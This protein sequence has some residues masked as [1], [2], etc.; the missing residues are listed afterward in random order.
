MRY[1]CPTVGGGLHG[2]AQRERFDRGVCVL[3]CVLHLAFAARR[4]RS[5]P[6][7]A[8]RGSGSPDRDRARHRAPMSL[9]RCSPWLARCARSRSGLIRFTASLGGARAASPSALVSGWLRYHTFGV[10]DGAAEIANRDAE[11][12]K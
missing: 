2:L 12:L 8:R 5:L 10:S 1:G 9:V 11:L 4:R 6:V 3:G 7:L